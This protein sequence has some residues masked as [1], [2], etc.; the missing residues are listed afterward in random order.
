ME[1]PISMCS[2]QYIIDMQGFK[3]SAH[4]FIMREFCI[5]SCDASVLFQCLVN[6]P[7]EITELG[8]RVSKASRMVNR[9]LS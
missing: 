5:V 1:K 2:E 6:L 4:E 9:K 3:I 7:C 8:Q